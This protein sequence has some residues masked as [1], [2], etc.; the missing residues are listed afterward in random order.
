[1]QEIRFGGTLT[2]E[3]Y[4]SALYLHNLPHKYMTEFIVAIAVLFVAVVG[5]Y[6]SANFS[7]IEMTV[8]IFPLFVLL[9]WKVL[10]YPNQVRMLFFQQPS[11]QKVYEFLLDDDKLEWSTGGAPE[12]FSWSDF[13]SVRSNSKLTLLYRSESEFFILPHCWFDS[14]DDFA[15]FKACT[16]SNEALT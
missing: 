6:G 15:F 8:L 2:P 11:L 14:R 16:A 3:D 5:V 10:I 1:M 4:V 13:V 12:L 7:P 9:I